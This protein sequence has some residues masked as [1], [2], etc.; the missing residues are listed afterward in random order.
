[1]QMMAD[2]L[3]MPIRIH[4]FEHTCALG[5][6]IFASVVADIY[7]TIEEAMTG[8]GTGFD[9]E[10]FPNAESVAYYAGRYPKYKSLGKYIEQHTAHE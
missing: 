10:Y 2:V 8:M 5:A 9:A 3:D 6:A 1:M 7:P 4:R